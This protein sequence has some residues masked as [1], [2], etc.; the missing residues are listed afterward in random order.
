MLVQSF[1]S[2][3]SKIASEALIASEATQSAVKKVLSKHKNPI[4]CPECRKLMKNERGI[5]INLVDGD[6]LERG[7]STI[8]PTTWISNLVVT[9]EA[10]VR[11][12]CDARPINK[13]LRRTRFPT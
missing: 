5:F 13:S 7:N 9:G 2:L 3:F 10:K 11:L 4:A 8:G 1:A 12:T 6:E